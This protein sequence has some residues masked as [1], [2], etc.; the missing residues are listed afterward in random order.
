MLNH[1]A[2]GHLRASVCCELNDAAMSS[3]SVLA[4]GNGGSEAS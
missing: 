4:S 2:L 1:T 3:L